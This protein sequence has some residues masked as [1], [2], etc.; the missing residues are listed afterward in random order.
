MKMYGLAFVVLAFVGCSKSTVVLAENGKAKNAIVLQTKAG[1]VTLDR[2]GSYVDVSSSDD[3]PTTVKQMSNEEINARFGDVVNAH[4]SKP[5]KFILYF[6]LNSAVLTDASQKL[7]PQVLQT[8]KE[9]QPCLVDIIGHTDTIG[10]RKDNIKV[11]KKRAQS[12][13]TLLISEGMEEKAMRVRGYGEDDLLISTADNV[14]EPKNRNVEIL[15][16]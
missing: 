12:I 10:T 16:K 2:V 8:V 5:V 4:P 6:E 9:R 11:S 1:S 15:V 3:L 7:L 13:A 14:D